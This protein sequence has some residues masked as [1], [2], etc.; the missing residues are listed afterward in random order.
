MATNIAK[1]AGN[2]VVVTASP[3]L[4]A[5]A[6]WL[7]SLIERMHSRGMAIGDGVRFQLGWSIL[8]FRKQ[9]DETLVVCEPDFLRNPF[10]DEL[11]S[12]DVTLKVQAKQNEFAEKIGATPVQ[13]SFQDKV[14]VAKGAL[15][16]SMLYMERSVPSPEKGDSGWYIGKREKGSA[17]PELE[18]IY[19][20]QLLKIRPV[21]V[22]ALTLPAG[23]IVFVD[24]G[25]IERILDPN[26]KPAY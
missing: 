17:A 23:Y 22:D 12:V 4:S 6:E 21:L 1:I 5:Q 15:D 14:V 2:T 19:A 9:I 18:A 26:S 3:T 7:L 10:E 20:F 11:S 25:E 13:I 16:D 8:T 24:G